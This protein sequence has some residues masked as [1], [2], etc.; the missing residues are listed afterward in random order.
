[1]RWP[2]RWD[3]CGRRDAERRVTFDIRSDGSRTFISYELHT[4]LCWKQ[5]NV[6]FFCLFFKKI[7]LLMSMC[8][9]AVMR[10][11]CRQPRRPF[12]FLKI[13]I[14]LLP[15]H[16]LW[17]RTQQTCSGTVADGPP[18]QKATMFLCASVCELA[19]SKIN[20]IC[21]YFPF[22]LIQAQIFKC[23]LKK[24]KI[25]QYKKKQEFSEDAI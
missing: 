25:H 1:M 18:G 10:V 15:L 21:T 14:S 17:I 7:Y 16:L 2:R 23:V 22:F 3:P 8:Y 12:L 13:C 11:A 5:P 20:E 24:L 4:K 19:V 9:I 6:F